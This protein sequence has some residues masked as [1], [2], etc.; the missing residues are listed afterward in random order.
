MMCF[1]HLV[2]AALANAL[3]QSSEC[4]GPVRFI[5]LD[6][7]GITGSMNGR[8]WGRGW[9]SDTGR[10]KWAW[11]RRGLQAIMDTYRNFLFDTEGR[12]ATRWGGAEG[13]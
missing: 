7:I 6:G 12:R 11:K 4:P 13:C 3:I 2:A 1:V 10:H 9:L 5:G 8:R